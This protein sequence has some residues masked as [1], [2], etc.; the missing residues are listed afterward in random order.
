MSH[1]NDGHV[2]GSDD[3]PGQYHAQRQVSTR[4][5]YLFRNTGD[6]RQTAKA[7]K[8]QARRRKHSEPAFLEKA[9]ISSRFNAS[10]TEGNKKGK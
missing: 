9:L 8:N 5:L 4:V 1:C 10:R 3:R 2:E 7:H 6:L